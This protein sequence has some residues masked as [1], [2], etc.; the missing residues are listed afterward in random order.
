[1]KPLPRLTALTLA[2]FM[3]SGSLVAYAA[4]TEPPAQQTPAY[5]T[6]KR[7]EEHTSELQSP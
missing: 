4:T 3:S 1:M 2:A 6:Q 7:S 5:E